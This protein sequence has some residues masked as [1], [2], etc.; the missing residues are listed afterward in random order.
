[1]KLSEFGRLHT[2]SLDAAGILT[3]DIETIPAKFEV[4][5]YQ[6]GQRWL[7]HKNIVRPGEML[8]WSAKWYHEPHQV[9]HM[10]VT[11]PGMLEGLWELLDQA[12][13]VVGWNS[14]NFDLKKVRGYFLRGGLPPFR[15]AK[16]IDLI[17]TAR[18][19]GLES[20]ALDYVART[21]DL[22][23]KKSDGSIL[24]D[25][26]AVVAGDKDAAKLLRFYN[27]QDV[28]VTEDAFDM[29]RP[30]IK[31]HPAIGYPSDD[32]LR[33]PRCGSADV[34]DC[35]AFQAQVIRYRQ[36]RCHSC[37]GLFRTTFHSRVTSARS[38]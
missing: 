29:L 20:A 21:L 27:N 32:S 24:T 8:S 1:M 36:Y 11:E 33:C 16:S 14:D 6:Q 15:P 23:H 17:R 25:W 37:T 13:Y 5:T 35:G 12:S 2:E 34:H 18:S 10:N 22:P 4:E 31:N 9:R 7:G 38:V 26:K 30:W 28:R 19:F 3:F